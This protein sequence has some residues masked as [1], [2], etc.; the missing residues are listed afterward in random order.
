M[1]HAVFYKTLGRRI[2]LGMILKMPL[3]DGFVDV[4]LQGPHPVAAKSSLPASTSSF[5]TSLSTA[6][7]LPDRFTMME[8]GEPHPL[9]RAAAEHLQHYLQTQDEWYHNF[10]LLPQGKGAVIGKMF[11]VLVVRTQHNEL[12][13]LAA[14]SGKLAGG[15]HHTRFVPAVFDA[16]TDGS[17][18]N[19]GMTALTQINS[20]IK[21]MQD[22]QLPVYEHEIK[23]LK[24]KRRLHSNSLQQE[25]FTHYRFLNRSGQEKNLLTLFGDA[26]YK[27]PPAGAGEC[28][29][30][31]L[32]QYAFQQKMQ[33]I[34]LAEFW[35]GQSPKSDQWQHGQ[36]YACC[37]EKCAPILVHMLQG[38]DR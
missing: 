36:F 34:A 7:P 29:G 20:Q 15:N 38:I 21:T 5:F 10:G 16:L 26:G 33:P 37:K 12:G 30:P 8:V 2:L 3:S 25:L 11:G 22:E 6:V 27:N 18:L 24:I 14:F 32:L 13:Y 19:A 4:V 31:K 17:F 35:W 1:Q 23:L 9:C 28:A